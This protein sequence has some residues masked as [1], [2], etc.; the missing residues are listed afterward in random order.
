MRRVYARAAAR[1]RL[2]STAFGLVAAVAP[3]AFAAAVLRPVPPAGGARAA[4]AGPALDELAVPLV[5]AAAAVGALLLLALAADVVRVLA[6]KRRAAPLGAAPVRGAR[7][8][9]SAAVA[10]PTAIGYLHPAVI[11]PAGFRTRVDAAEWDAVLA[12]ECA[13]LARRDDWAKAVQS[14]LL[15]L[16]WWLPGLWLIGRALDLERELASDEQAAD[17]TG[18][19]RY[20]ACLLRLATDRCG[21]VAPALWGRRTHLAIRVERLLR[22]AAGGGP[23]AR[24]AALGAFTATA[25]AVGLGALVAVPAPHRAGPPPPAAVHRI[26]RH[27]VVAAR[28]PARLAA[29]RAVPSP[30]RP[31]AVPP[32]HRV[33]AALGPATAPAALRAVASVRPLAS[34]PPRRAHR[35]GGRPAGPRAVAYAVLER[36]PCRTCRGPETSADDGFGPAPGAAGSADAAPGGGGAA[37]GGAVTLWIR[38]PSPAAP[39]P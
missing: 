12:H 27:P 37:P 34:A 16:G 30:A 28:P 17:A 2:L 13:H 29:V 21:D 18:A 9:A 4:L 15:R 14:A 19:R 6:V 31:R 33:A 1:Y 39:N 3:F 26:V 35:A 36:R 23:V 5:L 24:A 20:A 8:G 7:L 10:T 22:P 25:F 38:L 11:V 32:P